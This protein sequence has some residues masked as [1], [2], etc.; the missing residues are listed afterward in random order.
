MATSSKH[1]L[2]I[3]ISLMVIFKFFTFFQC[4]FW[5][6]LA[7]LSSLIIK[8][9]KSTKLYIIVLC[10]IHLLIG[11]ILMDKENWLSIRGAEMILIMKIVSFT[12]DN[13]LLQV[14]ESPI[15]IFHYFVSVYTSVIG[16]WINYGQFIS[17]LNSSTSFW[18]N[19]FKIK[20][21]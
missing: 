9:T 19:K 6:S 1:V 11:E 3:L 10:A 5:I 4:I 8:L 14:N 12:F 21:G 15:S 20:I 2:S 18:V 13:S 16:T 17:S 7:V